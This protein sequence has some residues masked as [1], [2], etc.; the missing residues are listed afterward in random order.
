MGYGQPV[1][2]QYS[3]S[4]SSFVIG[5]FSTF[6]NPLMTLPAVDEV[7]SE[8]MT[9]GSKTH[10]WVRFAKSA[11]CGRVS[12]CVRGWASTKT[13]GTTKSTQLPVKDTNHT[14]LRWVEDYVV[15]FV[16]P[17]NNSR[18]SLRL[19]RKVLCVPVHKVVESGYL[20]NGFPTLNVH[21]LRLRKRNPRQGFYLTGEV[22][23]R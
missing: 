19:V 7:T 4:I 13:Y 12:I 8:L 6:L 2:L 11:S 16:V 21:H 15:Q 20:S 14:I 10:G 3:S 1:V 17:V 22:G 23:V 9:F 5:T 18:T